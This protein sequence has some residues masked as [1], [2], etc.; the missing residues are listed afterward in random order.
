[1][2]PN[3]ARSVSIFSFDKDYLVTEIWIWNGDYNNSGRRGVK[4][5]DVLVS[6]DGESL[7]LRVDDFPV[8]RVPDPIGQP[9]LPLG[10]H[11]YGGAWTNEIQLNETIRGVRFT[12]FTTFAD[13][14]GCGI[15]LEEVRFNIIPEPGTLTLFVVAVPVLLRRRRV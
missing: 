10:R 12:D 8:E 5:M 7:D 14:D 9:G 4:T 11:D 15:I 2:K 1:M 6:R 3:I 13:N